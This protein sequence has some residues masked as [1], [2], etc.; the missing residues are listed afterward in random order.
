MPYQ[1]H[2]D[3]QRHTDAINLIIDK[4]TPNKDSDSGQTIEN[5]QISLKFEKTP[6]YFRY[7]TTYF[8]TYNYQPYEII[9]Y[10]TTDSQGT[11][12]PF[13]LNP[14]NGAL[15]SCKDADGDED[16]TCGWVR[17]YN[18]EKIPFSQGRCCK[19]QF[20]QTV[21][22]IDNKDHTRGLLQCHLFNNR[23]QSAHCLRMDPLYY[24]AFIVGAAS[25]WCFNYDIHV[26]M[27][28]PTHV[29]PISCQPILS[30][31]IDNISHA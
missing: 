28:S 15:N 24:H 10:G 14:L 20:S 30:E 16:P 22:Q 26:H 3:F 12:A 11:F 31:I 17:G 29:L 6:V 18:N 19:C 2:C 25:N 21:F 5:K 1:I 23:Q 27:E 13:N 9:S 7:P 4:V 8:R